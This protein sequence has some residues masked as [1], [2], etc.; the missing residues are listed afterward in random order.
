MGSSLLLL[1][2]G[3]P[4]VW[5]NSDAHE[6]VFVS[7]S[8]CP[9][10][11]LRSGNLPGVAAQSGDFTFRALQISSFDNSS[12]MRTDC[13]AYLGE[14][15]THIWY[16]ESSTI[17]G[18]KPWSRGN[19]SDQQ[20]EMLQHL[21]M[22]Y[23]NGFKRDVEE[24][25]KT[26]HQAYPLELQVSKML[27]QDEGSKETMKLLLSDT[28]PQFVR[29]VLQAGKS[30]L[31]K[32]EKPD[33]WLSSGPSPGPDSL[34][35]VCHVSGFYPKPVWVMWMQGDQEEP[36]TQRGDIL[37]NIDGTWYLRVTVDVSTGEADRL[38]CRVKHSSLGD[39]DII[40]YWDGSHVSVGKIVVAVLVPILVLIIGLVWWIMRRRKYVS[41]SHHLL[42]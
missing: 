33:A 16:N 3:L 29:A 2:W 36:A 26:L 6:L 15:Q 9:G 42:F 10:H 32:Q 23:R 37:P 27:N 13:S 24:L 34:L 40:L 5:G 38:S 11:S 30:D 31:E 17:R 41:S 21:F 19:F 12:W 28:C 35:L 20:W 39:Q 22:I 4:Q 25:V 7:L 8:L 1:L 18:L 14:V